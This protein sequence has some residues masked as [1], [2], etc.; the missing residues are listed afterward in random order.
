[1][2]FAAFIRFKLVF[3]FISC[4]Y[5]SIAVAQ[6]PG[7]K[8]LHLLDAV[9]TETSGLIYTN[10]MLLSHTDSGGEPCLY[11]INIHDGHI[12]NTYC[13]NTI[14]N[15]D[16]EDIAT[17]GNAIYIGDFGN[18]SGSRNPLKIYRIALDD[19][20]NPEATIDSISFRF[21]DQEDYT[22]MFRKTDYDC[23]AL[24]AAGGRLY[25][26]TK[27][28]NNKKTK[29]Y[30]IPANPGDYSAEPILELD[31]NGLITGAAFNSNTQV[32][33]L[34][35]YEKTF[36]FNPLMFLIRFSGNFD[37]IINYSR[38]TLQINNMQTEGITWADDHT[39][40]ITNESFLK[41]KS[42]LMK[43]DLNTCTL[44]PFIKDS[45]PDPEKLLE[46][47]YNFNLTISDKNGNKVFQ[48]KLRKFYRN[49]DQW[50]GVK[51]PAR[52]E[53]HA[54]KASGWFMWQ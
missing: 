48:G 26:F 34:I 42:H 52:I 14:H 33:A 49:Q 36:P 10:N 4:I 39:L 20:G 53:W 18:N 25:V 12:L 17:D 43:S 41:T 47:G 46:T 45:L 51:K 1:V 35:A 24:F 37:H 9:L 32:L 5:I 7:V 38:I 27:N 3:V 11:E 28:W 13:Y 15:Y 22:P 31:V 30:S 29:M 16:W 54:Q 50:L 21:A 8:K 19:I 23:E 44:L 40:L 6:S 2:T